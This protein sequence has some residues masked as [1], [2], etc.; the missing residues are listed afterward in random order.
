MVI[1]FLWSGKNK[2]S[3][4]HFSLPAMLMLTCSCFREENAVT[5]M[6]KWKGLEANKKY[7]S[8]QGKNA[9]TGIPHQMDFVLYQSKRI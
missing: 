3:Q 5:G 2:L 6:R 4:N 7:F 1:D 9:G 8:M